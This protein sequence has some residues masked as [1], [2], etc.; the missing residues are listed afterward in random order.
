VPDQ[1][2]PIAVARLQ[3]G[4]L[5]GRL[6][7]CIDCVQLIV[8]STHQEAAQPCEDENCTIQWP[9]IPLACVLRLASPGLLPGRTGATGDHEYNVGRDP[10]I[11][12]G[13]WGIFPV[14]PQTDTSIKSRDMLSR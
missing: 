7:F 1:R 2:N 5:L 3:L 10:I 12:S 11:K 9:S 8:Q 6:A 13:N 4:G 14:V